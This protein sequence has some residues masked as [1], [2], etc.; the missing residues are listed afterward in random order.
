MVLISAS[1]TKPMIITINFIYHHYLCFIGDV[2]LAS[3][4]EKRTRDKK[5]KGTKQVEETQNKEKVLKIE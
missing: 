4:H 2:H 3:H 5:T 1:W